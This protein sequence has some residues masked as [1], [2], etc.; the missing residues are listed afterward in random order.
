[1]SITKTQA[2]YWASKDLR[3]IQSYWDGHIGILRSKWLVEQMKSMEFSSVFEIG[4]FA[5][6]NLKYI[7]DAF[8]QSSVNGLEI[9]K[10]AFQFAKEKL[11]KANLLNMDLHDMHNIK[12]KYDLV[13]TSGVL[14]HVVPED[15][16]N[17]IKKCLNLSN[18]YML[19]IENVGKNEVV[20][21]PKHLNPT[22][23][24]SDQMQWAPDLVSIYNS[25]GFKV[26]V[27]ELP[28]DCRT[29]GASE[30]LIIDKNK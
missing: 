26:E 14:I 1:M 12:N 9:N 29:N 11:P 17:V 20:A 28:K 8:P 6:R 25:M 18:R 23:K 30:L 2:K 27:I 7:T 4:Y 24:V 5:G 16:S 15:M 19:H 3:A 22:Y 10:T 13:F 21:G